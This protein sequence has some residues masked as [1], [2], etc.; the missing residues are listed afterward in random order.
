MQLLLKSGAS[1]VRSGQQDLAACNKTGHKVLH[2]AA[3]LNDHDMIRVRCIPRLLDLSSTMP[4][5]FTR[6]CCHSK[7]LS[8]SGFKYIVFRLFCPTCGSQ[9]TRAHYA[10]ATP[11]S[12]PMPTLPLTSRRYSHRLVPSF[13]YRCFHS[14]FLRA[15]LTCTHTRLQSN[16]AGYTALHVAAAASATESPSC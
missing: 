6:F 4:F 10:Q 3:A 7:A 8:D 14:R 12:L 1:V 9:P 11:L 5:M 13:S 15:F 16:A 2:V